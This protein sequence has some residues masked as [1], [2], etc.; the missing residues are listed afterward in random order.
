MC[1]YSSDVTRLAAAAVALHEFLHAF[2]NLFN[3]CALVQ[4]GGPILQVLWLELRRNES[5]SAQEL[6]VA[7]RN[8]LRQIREGRD[9]I[10]SAR[11]PAAEMF[12]Y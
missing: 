12:L 4:V 10:S 9:E 7:D 2:E 8:F 1:S 3:P 6:R 11:I 5:Q